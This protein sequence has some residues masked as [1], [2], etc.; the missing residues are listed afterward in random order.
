MSRLRG[1]CLC[2]GVAYT[3]GPPEGRA[4]A[5]HCAQCR[6]QSGHHFAAVPVAKDSVS[7]ETDEGL[8]WYRASNVGSRGFCGACGSTLFWRGD[9]GPCVHVLMASLDGDTG[10]K[11]GA[12][13]WVSEQGDYYD[14]GGD[15]PQFQEG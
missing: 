10:L 7:F 6:R 13:V 5:C 3:A 15:L 4:I 14:I 11:L 1:S 12:H 8:K 2:G 9:D